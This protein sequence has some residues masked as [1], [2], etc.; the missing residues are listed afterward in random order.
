MAVIPPVTTNEHVS[1]SEPSPTPY[2]PNIEPISPGFPEHDAP[3]SLADIVSGL[4]IADI[5]EQDKAQIVDEGDDEIQIVEEQDKAQ[6]VEEDDDD[7]QIVEEVI[8][9][10]RN[11]I[12]PNWRDKKIKKE[13][14]ARVKNKDRKGHRKEN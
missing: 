6:M 10:P 7:I 1:V 4:E 12:P 3:G 8:H 13:G 11:Q 9:T 5:E 14:E 2:L